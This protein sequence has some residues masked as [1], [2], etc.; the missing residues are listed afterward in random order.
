MTTK[1]RKTMCGSV[2]LLSLCALTA[3]AQELTSPAK[4]NTK[5]DLCAGTGREHVVKTP[6]PGR[7]RISHKPSSGK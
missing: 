2:L 4:P 6:G 5:Q 1:Q 7:R 3:Y